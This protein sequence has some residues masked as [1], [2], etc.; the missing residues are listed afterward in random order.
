VDSLELIFS[1]HLKNRLIERSIK[2]E[3]ILNTVDNFDKKVEIADDEF[4]FYKRISAN[5]NRVLKVVINPMSKIIVTAHF[6][7]TFAKKINL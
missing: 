2:E 7:R 6:D 4:Y 3:W 5:E 1:Q